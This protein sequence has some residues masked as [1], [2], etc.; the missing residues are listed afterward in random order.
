MQDTLNPWRNI[1]EITTS[2]YIDVFVLYV[3]EEHY[4]ISSK[5]IYN[6]V[7]KS[8]RSETV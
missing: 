2:E 4:Y 6:I 7:N 5:V 8:K 1:K 3:S